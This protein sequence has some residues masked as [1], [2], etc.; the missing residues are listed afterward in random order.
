MSL[1]KT[2]LLP[3]SM[4]FLSGMLVISL[5]KEVQTFSNIFFLIG[6]FILL[7]LLIGIWFFNK[8]RKS[9]YY[10]INKNVKELHQQ[11]DD[12]NDYIITLKEKI[13]ETKQRLYSLED[14]DEEVKEVTEDNIS[15]WKEQV[16]VH[17]KI[18]H[19]CQ[20]RILSLEKKKEELDLIYFLVK[21]VKSEP[22]AKKKLEKLE[23][24]IIE[25]DGK[26]NSKI[27]KEIQELIRKLKTDNRRKNIIQL[28]KRI[29]ELETTV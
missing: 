29:T 12:N 13:T 5:I 16:K 14:I 20:S 3:F 18:C 21:Q 19:I 25:I 4:I 10:I 23:K 15:L 8:H 28:Q 22:N 9:I 11:I 1:M 27:N 2:I 26:V 17:Y 24:L 6:F 7:L